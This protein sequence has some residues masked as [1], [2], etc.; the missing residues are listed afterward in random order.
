M[1][2]EEDFSSYMYLNMRN[3]YYEVRK[4]ARLG[5]NEPDAREAIENAEAILRNILRLYL[6]VRSN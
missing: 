4:A 2:H 5:V 1:K 6:E 3:A